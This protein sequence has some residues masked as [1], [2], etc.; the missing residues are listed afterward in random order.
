MIV[1]AVYN[2]LGSMKKSDFIGLE[3][4]ELTSNEIRIVINKALEKQDASYFVDHVNF[5]ELAMNDGQL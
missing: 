1:S 2:F 5:F 3:N 4:L